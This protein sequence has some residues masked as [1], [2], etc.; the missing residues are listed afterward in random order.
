MALSSKKR[1]RRPRTYLG[2][3]LPGA[4]PKLPGRLIV[5][6][7][8]DGSGRT[9]YASRL[10]LD[11][12]ARGHAVVTTGLKRSE[13]VAKGIAAAKS[14]PGVG[15]R[16]MTL[17]YA[18]DFADQLENLIIPSLRNGFVVLCDRFV[19]TLIARAAVRGLDREWVERIYGIALQPDLVVYLRVAPEVL[20][21]RELKLHHQLDYWESGG[22][23]GISP[24]PVR[25]FVEYQRRVIAEL[26]RQAETEGFEVVDGGGTIEEVYP[27]LLS[28]VET[29]LG[30]GGGGAA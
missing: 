23:L 10:A 21:E 22:D 24:D 27:E 6:E 5:I 28:R 7:G 11:L 4:R 15:R 26:E 16:T 29:L 19:Y 3:G 1:F 9:T 18:A 2:H 30:D 20:L 14:S 25:S 8:P 12:Q 13:L 17:F